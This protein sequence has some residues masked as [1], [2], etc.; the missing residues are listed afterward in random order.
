MNTQ[1]NAAPVTPHREGPP[2]HNATACAAYA[3]AAARLNQPFGAAR[4]PEGN[5]MQQEISVIESHE[6]AQEWALIEQVVMQGDLSKLTP[7]QRVFYYNKVC[8]SAGLNPMTKPLAYLQLNGK[9]TLYATKDCTEQLRKINGVSIEELEGRVIDDIYIV[10]ARAKDKTGRADES[11]GAVVIGSLKGE[12]KAN[13]IMKA[14]TKAKRRVTLSIC[15]MGCVDESETDYIP[16]AQHVDI[17]ITTGEYKGQQQKQDPAPIQIEKATKLE[18][19]TPDQVNE[20]ESLID[21]C[22]PES[23]EILYKCMRANY[24]IESIHD[25]TPQIY[26]RMRKAAIDHRDARREMLAAAHLPSLTP[27]EPELITQGVR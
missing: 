12:M 10:R 26:A 1:R 13:A 15:G 23:I 22:S 9:L 7:K 21:E 3:N 6:E 11:T 24:K 17:D 5:G 27:E 4:K 16:G 18:K 25:L 20:L 19:I 2:R 8:K 14:E